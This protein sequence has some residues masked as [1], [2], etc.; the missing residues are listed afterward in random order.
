MSASASSS[1]GSSDADQQWEDNLAEL[2]II[3]NLVLFPFVGKFL[4]RR[5]AYYLWRIFMEWRYPVQVNIVGRG[6]FNLFGI[7]TSLWWT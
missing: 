1:G 7:L 2:K 6:S 4:G 3:T 5:F